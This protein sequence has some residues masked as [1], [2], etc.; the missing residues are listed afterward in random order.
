M[1]QSQAA[2][3]TKARPEVGGKLTRFCA[4]RAR[5]LEIDSSNSRAVHVITISG[6]RLGKAGAETH[7]VNEPLS[8]GVEPDGRERVETILAGPDRLGQ[9]LLDTSDELILLPLS[10]RHQPQLSLARFEVEC[11]IRRVLETLT[12]DVRR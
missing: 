7:A 4:W 12:L 1:L 9:H 5:L 2:R 3:Q 6:V 11:V 10:L 8:T